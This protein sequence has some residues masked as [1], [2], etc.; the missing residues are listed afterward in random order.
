MK[1]WFI[2]HKV[3]IRDGVIVSLITTAVLKFGDWLLD[4]V[5]TVGLSIFETISNILYTLAATHSDGALL[6]LI[7]LSGFSIMV[8]SSLKNIVDSL[9]LY[10]TVVVLER[11]SSK[12]S[13]DDKKKIYEKALDRKKNETTIDVVEKVEK[14]ITI[15]KK[16]GKH[17]F[18]GIVLLIVMYILISFYITPMNLTNKFSQDIVKITPYI[19]EYDIKKLESDWVC[20]RSKADYD[21]IYEVINEVK[22]SNNLPD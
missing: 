6:R 1:E 14:D 5:P 11:K 18:V 8:G 16:A 17:A 22:E 13:D 15:G 19:E 2:K 21:K 9:K 20:M 10:R 7:I 4:V 3:K 12:L